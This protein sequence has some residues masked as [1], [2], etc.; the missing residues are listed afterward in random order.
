LD[1]KSRIPHYEEITF[2]DEVERWWGKDWGVRTDYD[3]LKLLLLHRPGEEISVVN[4]PEA[5][6]WSCVVRKDEI[7][8]YQKEH[9]CFADTI[10][11]EGVE[12]AYL[13]ALTSDR[14][15]LYFIRDTLVTVD[16]GA[17]IGRMALDIRKGEEKFVQKRLADLGMPILHLV[18]GNGYFEGGNLILVDER[19]ALIGTGIR[20]NL[21][22]ATQ[23]AEVLRRCGYEDIRIIPV[24]SY[25]RI[26]PGGFSHLDACITVID[27]KTALVYAEGVPYE[28]I[29]YFVERNFNLIEVPRNEAERNGANVLVI[30][31]GKV[32]IPDVNPQTSRNLEKEGVDAIQVNISTLMR[33]GGGPRCMSNPLIREKKHKKSPS[34]TP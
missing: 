29:R 15:K 2:P 30:R 20:T 28:I 9:D 31:P 19:T 22:G 8:Q 12:V 24:P 13:N 34:R 11:K 5:W 4:D 16:G 3:P 7:S 10:R 17:V 25:L 14:A 1:F 26:W 6:T 21:E 27:E 18:H 32:V 23:V 33:G